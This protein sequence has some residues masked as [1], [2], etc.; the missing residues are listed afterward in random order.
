MRALLIALLVVLAGCAAPAVDDPGGQPSVEES[1]VAD[2]DRP[3][4]IDDVGPDTD[5]EDRPTDGDRDADDGPNGDQGVDDDPN[6]GDRDA[7]DGD[8]ADDRSA[9]LEVRGGELP[10]DEER[11]F[12]RVQT[13][14]GVEMRPP[15]VYVEEP[16]SP[17]APRTEPDGFHATMNLTP[18]EGGDGLTAGGV[19]SPANAV[20]V[21]PG[22]NATPEEIE[23]VFVHELVHA[24]QFQQGVHRDVVAAIPPDH[25]DTTDA[26][27]VR[28]AVME[29]GAVY[30]STAYTHRYDADVVPE[31]ES[32]DA[33][34]EEATPW[35]RLTAG[36]YYYG[37]RYADAL[38][39]SPADHWSIY[40]DPPTTMATVLAAERGS[41][42][43][44]EPF[45]A[46]L[47]ADDRDWS[48]VETDTMGQ[49]VTEQVLATELSAD[50]SRTAADGWEYD[51]AVRVADPGAQ[52][53]AHVWTIRFADAANASAFET[54]ATAYL[55]RRAEGDGE[56][57]V[58]DGLTLDL[59]TVDDR[60]VAILAGPESVVAPATVE[61]TDGSAVRV[62]PADD[63]AVSVSDGS[64]V[65]TPDGPIV[66]PSADPRAGSDGSAT[67]TVSAGT[68]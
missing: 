4:E 9:E 42:R 39:D 26:D 35:T 66:G 18:P 13:M 11:T 22:E 64:L 16:L 38:A 33:L 65:V 20:Y 34:Y 51:R 45:E 59:E 67:G 19:A 17:A 8:G 5:G 44:L 21:L 55:D 30:G 36:P 46:R 1:P 31:N 32:I 14:L 52:R 3:A 29:A 47:A 12:E 37:Y 68:P 48:L 43:E 24:A 56:P 57:R 25:R 10:F 6:D 63:P 49:Y 23:R 58:A 53:D 60:T 15:T 2:G 62:T 50:R 27:L 40:E 61:A 54:A 7:D 41:E 28:T